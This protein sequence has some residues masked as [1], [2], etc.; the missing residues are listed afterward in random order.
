MSGPPTGAASPDAARSDAA[1]APALSP[2]TRRAFWVATALLPV[3]FFVLLEGGLRLF[4]Y[5]GSY[6]LFVEAE[7]APPGTLVPSRDV[8]RRYFAN[9]NPPTPNA[10][11]FLAEKPPGAFRI[12][13]QGG[14]SA[15]GYPFYRGASFAQILNTRLG[16]AYPDREVEVVNTAMAA[17]N[18]FTLVDLADEVLEIEPDAVLIYAGHNE[19]YGALGAASTESVG[20]S[21]GLVRAYLALRRFRTVQLL[22]GLLAGVQRAS[23]DRAE[24][25]PPSNT[26]MARMVGEQAVPYGS[27]VYRA[28]AEQFADNLGALLAVY[29]RAG[30]PVWIGTLA[31][32]ERDQRPFVTAHAAGVDEGAWRADLDRAIAAVEGGA[33][34]DALRA[35]VDQDTLAADAPFVL[36]HALL[37]A[38][39]GPGARRAFGRARD[40]DALR[41]RAPTAF[42]GIIR[43][44]AARH[45]ATVVEVEDALRAVS[46]DGLVGSRTMLEHLHP[47]LAGYAVIADA[48]FQALVESGRV[49]P[50]PQPTPPGRLVKLVTAMDSVAGYIRLDQLTASWPFRPSERRPFRLDTT[51]TPAFVAERARATLAGEPWLAEADALARFYEARRDL[52]GA[53]LT[54]RAIVQAYPFLAEPYV[55]LANLELRRL[56]TGDPGEM[57]YVEGLYGQALARDSANATAH[58]MLG[59]LRLQGGDPGT[60]VFH[61]QRAVEAA[62]A[63]TR[64]L[65]NL[66]GAYAMLGRWDEAQAA[67]ARLVQIEPGNERFARLAAGVRQRRM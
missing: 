29:E 32:N 49:G 51:R 45:G 25:A 22:R 6:P 38:G 4:G 55:H 7:G 27:D 65:Y 50:A 53:L 26:L 64:P 21:P 61:L 18:S 33:G 2:G 17:V 57:A 28:G 15:A 14:S 40:L 43:Q 52:A 62:P 3:V 41:F 59:A 24:G 11:F 63:E 5:G 31:S 12:V 16:L 56:S 10:D 9:N 20:G 46:P 58:A 67:A 36:G 37:A 13:V 66:A 47:N 1:D 30:V 54:R 8:A 44:Q 19:Y 23:A 39:D 35:V 48:F 60:A 42:N 34:P